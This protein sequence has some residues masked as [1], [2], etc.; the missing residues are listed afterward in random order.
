MGEE[1]P[2]P[3]EELRAMR[4]VPHAV[5]QEVV[6]YLGT[7]RIQDCLGLFQACRGCATVGETADKMGLSIEAK[8]DPSVSITTADAG[9]G[10]L[11]DDS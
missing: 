4:A 9:A 5:L 3:T 7:Q 11:D 2:S 10:L 1:K 8:A 6:N